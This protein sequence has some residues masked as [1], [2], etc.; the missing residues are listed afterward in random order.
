[1]LELLPKAQPPPQ[2][3]DRNNEDLSPA[4]PVPSAPPA[5]LIWEDTL[6]DEF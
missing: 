6:D 2:R 5:E 4:Q 1:M 3:I